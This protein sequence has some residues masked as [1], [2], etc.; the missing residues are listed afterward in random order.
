MTKEISS[1]QERLD[2]A[3]RELALRVDHGKQLDKYMLANRALALEKE[4]MQREI[5]KLRSQIPAPPIDYEARKKDP[6]NCKG[7]GDHKGERTRRGLCSRCLAVYPEDDEL[8]W[9]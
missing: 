7:C 1:L 6:A 8:D 3:E 2:R 5:S 9:S 4:A